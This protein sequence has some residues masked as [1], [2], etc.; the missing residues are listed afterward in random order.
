LDI[1]RCIHKKYTTP[2]HPI[3]LDSYNHVVVFTVGRARQ[4][5]GHASRAAR[6]VRHTAGPYSRTVYIQR[7]HE[8]THSR[9]PQTCHPFAPRVNPRWA[10][11]CAYPPTP[12]HQ[13]K[14]CCYPT[15]PHHMNV[16]LFCCRAGESARPRC[17]ARR[18]F[19][20]PL[21][22]SVFAS[23]THRRRRPPIRREVTIRHAPS[24]RRMR[25]F[26][27]GVCCCDSL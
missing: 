25:A 12:P 11:L 27:T 13:K 17:F 19:P 23:P 20:A 15:L 9:L 16:V 26:S 10:R 8:H 7:A 3:C 21:Y 24:R 4:R 2:A 6:A 18:A 1:S 5:S 14:T 22:S